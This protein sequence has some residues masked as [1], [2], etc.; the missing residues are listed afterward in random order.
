MSGCSDR[1][2]PQYSSDVS[3]LRGVVD[4]KI[5]IETAKWEIFYHPEKVG[6]RMDNVEATILVAEI[7]PADPRWLKNSE[8]TIGNKWLGPSD[9][10]PWI[11]PELRVILT[12]EYVDSIKYNCAYYE[13][14]GV[15]SNDRI[16]GF[17]CSTK[18]KILLYL[19][20][21]QDS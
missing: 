13:T 14:T 21:K 8:T 2:T 17:A 11:S 10:R 1:T 7:E 20:L 15:T 4:I 3:T 9:A 19:V 5:P 12:D 16:S 18:S 6:G